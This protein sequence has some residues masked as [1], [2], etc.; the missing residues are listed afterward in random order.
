[1][2]SVIVRSVRHRPAIQSRSTRSIATKAAGK[3]R[4]A[5]KSRHQ[6]WVDGK[7]TED[8]EVSFDEKVQTTSSVI[9]LPVKSYTVDHRRGLAIVD[10]VIRE[11]CPLH[12]ESPTMN[13]IRRWLLAG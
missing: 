5:T 1:M 6:D 11:T 13:L 3:S 9:P 12:L 4:P 7:T 10:D 2:V 8:I